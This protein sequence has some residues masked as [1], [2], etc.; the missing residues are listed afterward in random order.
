MPSPAIAI[1]VAVAV[2]I[3]A[4][5]LVAISHAL[6]QKRR[7]QVRNKAFKRCRRLIELAR[8]TTKAKDPDERRRSVRYIHELHTLCDEFKF[9]LQ[10]IGTNRSQLDMI[11]Y[12]TRDAIL[13]D[14]ES[15]DPMAIRWRLNPDEPG[16]VIIEVDGVPETEDLEIVIP[17]DLPELPATT[18]IELV[19]AA[20]ARDA[21]PIPEIGEMM[22]SLDSLAADGA[23]LTS[24]PKKPADGTPV[25]GPSEYEKKSLRD[26]LPQH[27]EFEELFGRLVDADAHPGAGNGHLKTAAPEPVSFGEDE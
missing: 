16:T 20:M 14:P 23:I 19:E 26:A 17:L 6:Q 1:A 24:P 27:H 3:V 11:I 13:A 8:M 12:L 2:A 4:A 9:E 18:S 25:P 21:M 15:V 7:N 5:V 10:E 22:E